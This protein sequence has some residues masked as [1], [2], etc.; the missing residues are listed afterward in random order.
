MVRGTASIR[1]G[2]VFSPVVAIVGNDSVRASS[3]M[4]RLCGCIKMEALM[5]P[6]PIEATTEEKTTTVRNAAAP[7]TTKDHK[8]FKKM[9]KISK[10]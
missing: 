1:T 7:G 3:F 4:R 9:P 6:L 10:W 8:L 2:V 5:L